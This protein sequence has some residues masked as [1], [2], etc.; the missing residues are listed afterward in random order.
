MGKKEGEGRTQGVNKMDR[1]INTQ[2]QKRKEKLGT[3]KDGGLES[4]NGVE[5]KMVVNRG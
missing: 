4:V 3:R 1:S 2:S 5:K